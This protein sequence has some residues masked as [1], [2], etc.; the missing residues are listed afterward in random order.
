MIST[1][2]AM[3]K[4][5]SPARIALRG[6][7]D[8]IEARGT[9]PVDGHARDDV[10]QAGEQQ[11]HARDIAVVLAGLVGAA[12]IDLVERGPIDV[13]MPLPSAP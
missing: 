9:Q 5:I 3:A 7:A 1:P 2:P 4:S 11:R 13:G 6:S 10:R 12:E 8:G